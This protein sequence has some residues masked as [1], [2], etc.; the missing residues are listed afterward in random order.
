MVPLF[1]TCECL[2]LWLS[3][4][5]YLSE[6]LSVEVGLN[7]ILFCFANIYGWLMVSLLEKRSIFFRGGEGESR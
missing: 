7:L 3:R 4:S 2:V 6:I 1:M 5:D